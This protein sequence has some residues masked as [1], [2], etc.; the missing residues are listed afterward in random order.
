MNKFD[1]TN[2]EQTFVTLIKT[3]GISASVYTDRPKAKTVENDFVVVSLSDGIVDMGTYAFAT[4]SIDL[5]AR[6]VANQKNGKRLSVMY[7]ALMGA[8]PA[9][10]GKYMVD[11]N[12][13]VFPDVADDYGFHARMIDFNITIKITQ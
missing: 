10:S 2:L 1:T 12:P 3:A 7:E 8:I 9:Q 5:F 13:K 11:R 4:L 6:D